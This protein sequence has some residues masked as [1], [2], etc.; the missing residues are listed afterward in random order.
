VLALH[1]LAAARSSLQIEEDSFD[2]EKES[3]S[4]KELNQKRTD[5]KIKYARQELSGGVM[6]WVSYKNYPSEITKPIE[7]LISFLKDANPS[8]KAK[9]TENQ[10]SFYDA[11]HPRAPT[12]GRVMYLN[13]YSKTKKHLSFS[14]NGKNDQEFFNELCSDLSSLNG[15][16]RKPKKGLF[17]VVFYVPLSNINEADLSVLFNVL[18]KYVSRFHLQ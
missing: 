2:F 7:K 3:K 18:E 15:S 5:V 12:G 16:V 4:F 6:D 10:I 8:I 11:S 1:F 14:L 9:Y 17:D 13:S